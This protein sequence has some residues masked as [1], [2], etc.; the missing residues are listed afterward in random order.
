MSRQNHRLQDRQD[1]GLRESRDAGPESHSKD[2]H[3]HAE[4][5]GQYGGCREETGTEGFVQTGEC[6][7]KCFPQSAR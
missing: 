1:W 3:V 7:E 2:E 5:E 6:R 4:E